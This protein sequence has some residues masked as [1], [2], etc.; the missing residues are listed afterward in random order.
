[1]SKK[2]KRT[3]K[4][5]SS[6]KNTRNELN[7]KKSNC[8]DTNKSSN[9]NL[10]EDSNKVNL[11]TIETTTQEEELS[12]P[13]NDLNS[14]IPDISPRNKKMKIKKA[15]VIG[16]LAVLVLGSGSILCYNTSKLE[17]KSYPGIYLENQPISKLNEEELKSKIDYILSDKI[18]NTNLCLQLGDETISPTL[19]ELGVSYNIDEITNDILV[20]NKSGNIF[21]DTLKRIALMI[22]NYDY[23]PKPLI[24]EETL[25]TYIDDINDKYSIE[26][27]NAI[28]TI[29]NSTI[30][31]QPETYGKEVDTNKLK[32]DIINAINQDSINSSIDISFVTTT[33]ILTEEVANKMEILGT[34]KTPIVTANKDRTSNIKLF[35]SKL[36][37]TILAPD[38]EFSCN[39]RAGSRERADGYKA[40]PG[41][42][43]GEVVPIV[44]GGI[45]QG[46]TTIYNALL[47]ADLEITERHPHSMPVTYASN[48]RDAAIA[49]NHKDLR[50]K[51]NT[52]NPIILNTYVT[53]DGYVVATIW[54]IKEEDNKTIEISVNHINSKA[55]DAYKKT[56]IDGELIKTELLSRDRYK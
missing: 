6:P 29:T 48:G 34:Y 3:N 25:S 43:N 30:S 4:N 45:C 26:A 1:M 44:A 32:K 18:E 5:A 40:A 15:I 38:E 22:N 9:N 49:G 52:N 33:P 13:K 51:N 20:F 28:V 37:M 50:F 31:T 7:N 21:I 10:A 12:S 41:Y 53:N 19:A 42:V 2:K 35:L 23:I 8:N 47:Y 11:D 16:S 24:D 56:Y 14:N 27:T 17:N 54:G 55:A 39:E 36:D 46:T